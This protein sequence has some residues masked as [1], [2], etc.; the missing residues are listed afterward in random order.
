M[1]RVILAICATAAALVFLLSFKS[2]TQSAALGLAPA[3]A[4]GSPAPGG[5]GAVAATGPADPGAGATTPKT[6]KT[7]KTPGT[8]SPASSASATAGT[9]RTVT[10]DA[11]STIYGP[12]QVQITV[13][14]GKITAVSTPVY[15]NGT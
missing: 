9:A 12:V 14:G 15:P 1:R 5:A 3:S 11:V 8:A 4:A 6:P 2:H 7:P 13:K 10:G